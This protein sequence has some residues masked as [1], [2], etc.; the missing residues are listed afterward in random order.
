MR[1]HRPLKLGTVPARS[2]VPNFKR[3]TRLERKLVQDIRA[4]LVADGCKPCGTSLVANKKRDQVKD[5]D[6]ES[7]LTSI[8]A[9]SVPHTVR[10]VNRPVTKRVILETLVAEVDDLGEVC[11]W[12][13]EI[14]TT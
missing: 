10:G 4:A 8:V 13:Y 2:E 12:L 6:W 14:E 5:V 1:K 3:N 11:A 7:D 9:R